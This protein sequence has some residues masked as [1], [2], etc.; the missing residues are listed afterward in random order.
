MGASGGCSGRFRP[1]GDG[2]GRVPACVVRSFLDPA[3]F[4]FAVLRI[5]VVTLVVGEVWIL[6]VGEVWILTVAAVVAGVLQVHFFP[7]V[8]V[9]LVF[10]QLSCCYVIFVIKFSY[11]LSSSMHQFV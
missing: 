6:V 9:L 8:L 11:M 4:P 5:L 10:R 7:H 3:V 1:T 2:F